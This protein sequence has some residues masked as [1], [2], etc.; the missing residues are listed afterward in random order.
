M[1]DDTEWFSVTKLGSKYEEQV[2]Y[3]G[4]FWR[5]RLLSAATLIRGLHGGGIG[6]AYDDG[7]WIPGP[8]PQGNT[9]TS[10]GLS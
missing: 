4:R 3:C 8:A 9:T 7:D 5:H 6:Y 1:S 2:S 10:E